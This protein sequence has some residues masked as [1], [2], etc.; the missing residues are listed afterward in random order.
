[1]VIAAGNF[2][3]GPVIDIIGGIR[4]LQF[5]LVGLF[6]LLSVVSNTHSF[7]TFSKCWIGVDFMFSAIWDACLSAIHQRIVP[8]QWVNK[9]SMLATAARLGN[10]AAFAGF[11]SVLSWVLSHHCHFPKSSKRCFL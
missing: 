4:A 10:V 3:L 2:L 6:G 7:A 5:S 8:V 11:S 9:V 1:M